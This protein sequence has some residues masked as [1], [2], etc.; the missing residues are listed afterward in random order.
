MKP[1]LLLTT[2]LTTVHV[3]AADAD[4]PKRDADKIAFA[5]PNE[6]KAELANGALSISTADGG[7]WTMKKTSRTRP[8]LGAKPPAGATVLFDIG[9]TPDLFAGGHLDDR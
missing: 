7:P 6:F 9:K 8:T 3:T 2:L 5:G 1:I 4:K